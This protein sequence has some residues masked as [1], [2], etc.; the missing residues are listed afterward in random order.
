M[1]IV[2]PAVLSFFC[3]KLRG[4]RLQ[5]ALGAFDICPAVRGARGW[6]RAGVRGQ[7]RV[8]SVLNPPSLGDSGSSLGN[9]RLSAALLSSFSSLGV[10]FL[11]LCSLSIFPFLSL[12]FLLSVF[13]R[14][15]FLCLRLS[16]SVFL[17]CVFCLSFCLFSCLCLSLSLSLCTLP[18]RVSRHF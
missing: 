17:S 12:I 3:L 6:C 8:Q 15:F 13:L 18:Y 2:F 5:E 14:A 4:L 10:F 7:G 1:G 9:A 16:L 11:I